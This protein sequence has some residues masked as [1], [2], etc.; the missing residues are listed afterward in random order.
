LASAPQEC[1][2]D[3][4]GR[5]VLATRSRRGAGVPSE[6]RRDGDSPLLKERQGGLAGIVKA[7][8][9][10]LWGGR[11]LPA[12]REGMPTAQRWIADHVVELVIAQVGEDVEP[13]GATGDIEPTALVFEHQGRRAVA[14]EPTEGAVERFR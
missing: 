9:M 12:Q 13:L 11:E 10:A 14:A 8:E 2:A 1:P 6:T 4:S 5:R 7:D 3:E